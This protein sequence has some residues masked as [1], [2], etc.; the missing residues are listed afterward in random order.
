MAPS[1]FTSPTWPVLASVKM[2]TAR[3]VDR[4]VRVDELGKCHCRVDN[5]EWKGLDIDIQRIIGVVSKVYSAASRALDGDY[6]RL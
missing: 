2:H 3:F 5:S 4:V 1:L 6:A